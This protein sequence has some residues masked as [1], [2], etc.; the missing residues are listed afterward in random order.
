M[1]K[2]EKKRIKF[3]KVKIPL[4]ALLRTLKPIKQR[5]PQIPDLPVDK[6]KLE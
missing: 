2:G 4:V 5:F 6:V 3:P 1:W